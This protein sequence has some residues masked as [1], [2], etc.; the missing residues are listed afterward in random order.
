[1]PI[2]KKYQND[3]RRQDKSILAYLDGSIYISKV[4]KFFL[5]RGFLNKKTEFIFF[6]QWKSIEIDNKIDFIVAKSI[7]LKYKKILLDQNKIVK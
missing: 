6:D 4:N 3:V 7:Y 2:L 5:N 1:M